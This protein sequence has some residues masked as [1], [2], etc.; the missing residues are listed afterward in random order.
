M[1][2]SP[3]VCQMSVNLVWLFGNS[4]VRTTGVPSLCS[5]GVPSASIDRHMA[6]EPARVL[7]AAGEG[8]ARGHP[9][10]A[11]Y[12]LRFARSRSPG[13]DA[14]RPAEDLARNLRREQAAVI[15]QPEF[16]LMHQAVLASISAIASMIGTYCAGNNSAPASERGRSR[17]KR[18]RSISASTMA[19]GNSRRR[20]ISAAAA[21]SAGAISRDARQM[22]GAGGRSRFLAAG[23]PSDRGHRHSSLPYPPA[24]A[25][26][27]GTGG[28]VKATATAGSRSF[29][30]P[31]E[32]SRRKI[33][34]KPSVFPNV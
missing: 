5:R 10:A 2:R 3:I 12:D 32:P 30:A 23:C 6:A 26:H 33:S 28:A 8:P 1:P 31:A 4:I 25:L 9:I 17:R 20:S 27:R 18:P 24:A 14:A 19:S 29:R 7:A 16:W 34:A 15:E 13:E 11:G 21:A 22:V